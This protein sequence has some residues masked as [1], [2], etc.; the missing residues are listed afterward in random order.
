MKPLCAAICAVSALLALAACEPTYETPASSPVTTSP[1]AMYAAPA[2]T[3]PPAVAVVPPQHSC[4][5]TSRSYISGSA[6]NPPELPGTTL[7]CVNGT[8]HSI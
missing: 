8:W 3:A 5:Y 1:T 6:I 2:P 4:V 7:Q